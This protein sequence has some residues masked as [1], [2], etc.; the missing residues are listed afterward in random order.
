MVSRMVI[1]SLPFRNLGT[2]TPSQS[3][4]QVD[5]FR[6]SSRNGSFPDGREAWCSPSPV[7]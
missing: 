5:P 7:C 6:N 1:V 4:S 2:G 3:W